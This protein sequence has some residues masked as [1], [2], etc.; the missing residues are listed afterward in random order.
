MFKYNRIAAA[1]LA[2]FVTTA[3]QASLEMDPRE[4]MRKNED[5]RKSLN[6]S[7][8]MKM[9]LLDKSNNARYRWIDF[10]AD[11][12][13]PFNRKS[14]IRFSQPNDIKGTGFLSIEQGNVDDDLR[15]LY[16]PSLRKIR[17]ISAGNKTDSFMGT[18]W[19]YED[20][21]FVDGV[22]KGGNNNYKI[23]REEEMNGARCWV[24]EA[25]PTT[26]QEIKESGY[27]KRLMWVRQDNYVLTREE[28]FDKKGELAKI[29]IATEIKQI[30]GEENAWRAHKLE[31]VTVKT[32]HKTLIEYSAYQANVALPDGAF[33][34]RYLEQAR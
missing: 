8:Q 11:D 4:I 1:L 7:A 24:I 9:T 17:R 22:A 29:Q 25:T 2:G 18:D 12:T 26:E 33:T 34:T 10:I 13:D 21:E 23:V 6:E 28:K 30:P 16:L 5:A 15:W 19:W 27:S 20:F 31:M 3:A 14:L 32:G